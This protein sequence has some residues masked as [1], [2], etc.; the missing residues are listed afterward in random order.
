MSK[1]IKREVS[2]RAEPILE[3]MKCGQ[4]LRAQ[5]DA[6]EEVVA[7]GGL[8]FWLEPSGRRVGPQ[9]AKEVT[10]LPYI[11]ALADGLFADCPQSWRYAGRQ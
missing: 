10:R 1:R 2:K 5:V 6:R 9:A 11:E 4:V 7:K 8:F 3:Q